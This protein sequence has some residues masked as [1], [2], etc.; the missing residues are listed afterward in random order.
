MQSRLPE[1]C[2]HC[3]SGC[4]LHAEWAYQ[5]TGFAMFVRVLHLL[6]ALVICMYTKV[7]HSR[8]LLGDGVL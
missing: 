6:A 8:L 5:G 4:L 2:K 7:V 1:P 3:V